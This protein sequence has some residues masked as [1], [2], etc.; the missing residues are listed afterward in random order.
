LKSKLR[1]LIGYDEFKKVIADIK[2]KVFLKKQSKQKTAQKKLN[3]LRV[4]QKKV[5]ISITNQHKFYP[6]VVNLTDI[7]FTQDEED[8]LGKINKY[9]LPVN[10][11]CNKNITE[12]IFETE[13]ALL[14]VD[15]DNRDK[16]RYAAA[17]KL[18]KIISK[19]KKRRSRYK[20]QRMNDKQNRANK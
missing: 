5:N 10:P 2:K 3:R 13:T 4:T 14:Y 19:S 18:E 17:N 6:R 11:N 1:G 8:L 16:I 12:L 20:Q 7:P 9:N 15:K